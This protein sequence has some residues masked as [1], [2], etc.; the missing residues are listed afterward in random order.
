VGCNWFCF[1]IYCQVIFETFILSVAMTSTVATSYLSYSWHLN[2][3]QRQLYRRNVFCLGRKANFLPVLKNKHW[4]TE[5]LQITF[6]LSM[7]VP[8]YASSPSIQRFRTFYIPN[9]ISVT[10]IS[11]DPNILRPNSFHILHLLLQ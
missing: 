3:F 10:T 2:Y 11:L 7:S 8:K 4:F 6:C 9:L 5:Q 1:V